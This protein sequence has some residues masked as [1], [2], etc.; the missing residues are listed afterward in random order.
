MRPLR[1]R[2]T[3]GAEY[4]PVVGSRM[5]AT[6]RAVV[7]AFDGRIATTADTKAICRKDLA[8]CFMGYGGV[9]G[10]YKE[11]ATV[12]FRAAARPQSTRA[13]RSAWQSRAESSLPRSLL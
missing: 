2:M 6:S 4:L 13:I 7:V 1:T 5:R 12:R 9:P 10:L 8:I 3:D 11:G